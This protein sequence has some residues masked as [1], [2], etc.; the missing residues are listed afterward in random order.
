MNKIKE[1][2]GIKT[3]KKNTNYS[4]EITTPAPFN[5]GVDIPPEIETKIYTSELKGRSNK[6]E[7][8]ELHKEDLENMRALRERYNEIDDISTEDQ[9]ALTYQSPSQSMPLFE[10]KEKR[11][12]TNIFCGYTL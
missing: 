5:N 8:S 3:G 10:E 7:G 2:F 9:E 11:I 4:E 6:Y 12:K 1:A